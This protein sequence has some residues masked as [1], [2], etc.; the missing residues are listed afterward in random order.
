[1]DIQAVYSPAPGP[2]ATLVNSGSDPANQATHTY[3]FTLP[4][5][6]L[7]IGVFAS[8][9]D[10]I[11]PLTVEVGGNSTI[12]RIDNDTGFTGETLDFYEY[13]E[14]TGGSLNITVTHPTGNLFRSAIGVW[15]VKGRQFKVGGTG[16]GNP[17]T[18]T[19]VTSNLN[20]SP[21]SVCLAMAAQVD[22]SFT[23][24]VGSGGL[25]ASPQFNHNPENTW[26]IAGF[27]Q[28]ATV[29]GTP[30]SF[31]VDEPGSGALHLVSFGIW[32][33]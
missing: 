30:E 12:L 23:G 4:A 22:V 25:P 20:N 33:W 28:D 32:D 24:F 10:P 18:S 9:D 5:S 27:M 17:T 11:D 3:T 29:G 21:G 6:R 26:N 1:M 31:T 15:D 7:V 14:P 2:R 8:G 13:D 19:P 16:G